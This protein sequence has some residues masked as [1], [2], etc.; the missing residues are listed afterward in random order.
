MGL[1]DYGQSKQLTLPTRLAFARLIL[2]MAKGRK[3]CDS[4]AVSTRMHEMGLEFDNNDNLNIQA[5]MA[6]GMFDTEKTHRFANPHYS[7]L[8]MTCCS[9]C[10]QMHILTAWTYEN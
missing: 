7:F 10:V 2:E 4:K 6:F 1:I 8:S 9:L 5:M 3:N